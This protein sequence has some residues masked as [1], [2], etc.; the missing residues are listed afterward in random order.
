[1]F[2]DLLLRAACHDVKR[3]AAD[4]AKEKIFENTAVQRL[5]DDDD[6]DELV[7]RLTQDCD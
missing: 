7:T 2:L 5:T 4:D 6:G 3:H 1:M